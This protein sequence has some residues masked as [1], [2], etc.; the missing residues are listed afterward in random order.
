MWSRFF[1]LECG[2]NG[3]I[4]TPFGPRLKPESS[5]RV[6]LKHTTPA[7]DSVALFLRDFENSNLSIVLGVGFSAVFEDQRK[8]QKLIFH[9]PRTVIAI[10]SAITF[11]ILSIPQ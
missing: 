9:Q 6:S 2:L 7:N 11:H 5:R 8:N 1:V 3:R 10:L 4:L